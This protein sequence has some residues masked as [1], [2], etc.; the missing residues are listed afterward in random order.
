[1]NQKHDYKS[2]RSKGKFS[3]FGIGLLSVMICLGAQLA[4]A[5]SET[6]F[7]SIE[8]EDVVQSTVT[9]MVTDE[10]GTP[11]PGAN[12]VV[13]GTTN[14]TQT[15]F[16]GNFSLE[17]GA[18]ATLI[19]SYLGFV[20][21]EI[22]VNGNSTIN[23]TLAE[24]AAALDEVIVTGY[25]TETKRETTAAVSIVKAEELAA[26]PSGNVE[27]Q[28]QGRVAG[29]T[30]ISN[31]QPGTTSQVRVRG[32]NSF[33]NNSPL[34]VVDG[35]PTTNID[36]L[37]PDDI[38]NTSVLKDASA[39]SIYG[40][41]AANGVIVYT[42]KQGRKQNGKSRLS[43]SILGGVTDPNVA[44][45]P[46][47][48]NPQQMA[49]WTHRSYEN[50]AVAEGQP[51][52]T[53]PNYNHPQ[54]GTNAT[55]TFPDYLHAGGLNGVNAGDV[56]LA[57]V[58]AAYE[59]NPL[60][61]FLIK[62]NLQG[63]NWY[64]EITR[65][66]PQSR[67]SLGFDGGN[68]TG[69]FYMGIT[70]QQQSGTVLGQEFKRYT[71]R[72]NSE[73]DITPW[74]S[75]G[76]NFQTTYRS[77]VGLFGGNGGVDVA[78]DESE[79]LSAYRM[80]TIIPVYDEFGSF[81]STKASGFNNPRNP[82]RRLKRNN[83]DDQSYGIGGFGNI[84]A[85][86]KL[87]DGLTVRT[88]LGGTYNNYHFVDY[89]Y[90]YLG[91]SETEAND[92]FG[93]GGGYGYNY[94]FTNT[95]TYE[96]TFGK[97]G[98]FVLAGLE[99]LNTGAGR[100]ISGSGQNPFST[101]LDFQDLTAVQNPVVQSNWFKGANYTSQFG[102]L[103]YNFDEKYYV[104]GILRRDGSS[105]FGS[106]NRYGVF[107][108]VSAAWRV[109]DEAFMQNQDFISDLK[110]RGG[111][112]EM[113]NDTNVNPNNQYSLFGSDT[114]GT[115]YPISGQNSGADVGF[116]RS[117]IGNPAAKW[118]TSTT[119]NIGFDASFF[120]NKLDFVLDW[121]TKDTKDLLYQVPLPGVTGTYAEAPSVNI[122]SMSNK[123]V[124]FQIIG[125]GN[126]TEDLSFTVTLNNSFLS[127][128]I[129]SLTDNIQFFDGATYRGNSPI[130]NQVGRPIS[131]FFGYKVDGYFNSQA[132][133]DAQNNAQEAAGLE[134]EASLG[135]F[136]LVDT[137]NNG[138]I[139]SDDR[140][141]LGS[142]VPDWTGGAVINL[143]YK[144]IE[145]EMYWYASL[146]NEI[147]N[148]SKWYTDFQGTFEGSAKGEN[149]LN[150]WTP[151]LGNNATAPIFERA[152]NLF[153]SGASNSWYVEDG[154]YAR[155]QRLA[156]A[157]NFDQNI[158]DRIGISKMKLGFSCNNIWT[159]T[160]YTGLDPQVA[161][162]DTNFGVDV[163]NFPV[164]PSYVFSLELGL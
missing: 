80:P 155:L 66:A 163:G 44:G 36:F 84:Y 94:T 72:F 100:N 51:A 20:T 10:Q 145:L 146:G 15:D 45:A 127:N 23:A 97:H 115:W 147:Y 17:V 164:T 30:V 133:V 85:N 99:S 82:V 37:S 76:E 144:N 75:I 104:T 25:S 24:D 151:E 148:H 28:L 54:Y 35:V 71:A 60:E 107:P 120:N 110:F 67:F 125:R 152:T 89:N 22:A 119:L 13:K 105:R 49:E 129:T 154:S 83:G 142:A 135:R 58:R 1:M 141:F 68:E 98:L 117:R 7:S 150:S 19:F 153:T 81:A 29:V 40:A 126:F 160:N 121:W 41:R 57:A 156:L 139:N 101:D 42:T 140:T 46:G 87:M 32:F 88:S 128:E 48:L 108:A 61:T 77:T 6:N 102:Q 59:A 18:D 4:L 112:G 53:T 143:T 74:L 21:Q 114:G 91:D 161:G 56:D 162:P 109:I 130:R 106:E 12:V 65:I 136:K 55:P 95:L 8:L 16:D 3:S 122:A 137:D 31:G 14:G 2:V 64:K 132:E 62:P 149:V 138:I 93:E 131:A 26:I 78:D 79:V 69:R 86:L 5:S 63:T 103:K 159:I 70:A 38:L 157:Y 116:A 111:W 90:K 124:D 39:A 92:S 9:G 134:R 11:L 73:W 52:G 113:G 27:Q 43:I 34:Y 118:E 123:G 96:K 33:G 47:M 50:N 158:L